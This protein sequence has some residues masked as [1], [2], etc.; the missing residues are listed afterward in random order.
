MHHLQ[1]NSGHL[2]KQQCLGLTVLCLLWCHLTINAQESQSRF[3]VSVQANA[4]VPVGVAQQL[5]GIGLG[6]SFGAQ[7]HLSEFLAVTLNASYLN[8]LT[9]S[10]PATLTPEIIFS[11][12]HSLI[13]ILPGVRFTLSPLYVGL[14]AGYNIRLGS[15]QRSDFGIA[16][17]PSSLNGGHWSVQPVLGVLIPLTSSLLLDANATYIPYQVQKKAIESGGAIT[18]NMG[19]SWRL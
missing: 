15:I 14:Q 3:G 12:Q 2:V 11:A 6:A 1:K 18:L 16:Q 13:A 4:A 5:G 19:V 8:F 7:Y 17:V 10:Y 9:T